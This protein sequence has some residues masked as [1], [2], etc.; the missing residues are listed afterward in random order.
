M[1]SN[2]TTTLRELSR[3]RG[4]FESL[5]SFS[6][7][8]LTLTLN[9][10]ARRMAGK[11]DIWF[12]KPGTQE[13]WDRP[14][15]L[16]EE[17]WK[18][19]LSWLEFI[20]HN[21]MKIGMSQTREH[22]FTLVSDCGELSSYFVVEKE[23]RNPRITIPPEHLIIS[24]NDQ[25]LHADNTQ[26]RFAP[27]SMLKELSAL[28]YGLFNESDKWTS[29]PP[30]TVKIQLQCDNIGSIFCIL[31]QKAK[32]AAI[33]AIVRDMH[34]FATE[35]QLCIEPIWSRRS[36]PLAKLAD[37]GTRFSS[38]NLTAKAKNIIQKQLWSKHYPGQM[39]TFEPMSAVD[40][41]NI[42]EIEP[43]VDPRDKFLETT[44]CLI[45]VP[46]FFPVRRLHIIARFLQQ[47]KLH[48]TIVLF[49]SL[50]GNQGVEILKKSCLGAIT[51]PR[52]R[53]SYLCP[54][55]HDSQE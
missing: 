20:S 51:L 2:T 24:E 43:R 52:S 49:P 46:W 53:S 45:N 25:Y 37:H 7:H 34:S 47:L 1:S 8:F 10:V 40:I 16:N 3:I 9:Q 22:V 35:H 19:I 39:P 21:S 28:K 6:G 44:P 14:I 33:A 13:F 36:E 38:Y 18:M 54:R 30:G 48:S 41:L 4:K 50:R 31:R 17:F 55:I 26:S 15:P 29:F 42:S 11:E 5:T 32:N 27:S 12:Q 23:Q